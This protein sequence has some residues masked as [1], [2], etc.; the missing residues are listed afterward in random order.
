VMFASTRWRLT[1]WFVAVLALILTV[2]GVVV[3]FTTRASLFD[4]VDDSLRSRTTTE[5]RLLGPRLP[6]QIQPQQSL[7]NIVVGPVSTAGGYF[8]ALVDSDGELLAG[9]S[10]VDLE[11][12]AGQET[13]EKALAGDPSFE[14]T[15][16]STGEDLRVYVMPMEGYQATGL[17]LEVGRSIEPER[18]ALNRLIFI[19]GGGGAAGLVLALVGGFF[20]AG[21]ALRPIGA[22][23]DRQRAFVAD[24]SHELRTPL[25][26]IRAN[27]ELL[28]RHPQEPVQA[29][30]PSL[31]DIIREIDG[32]STLVS[33]M[34]TLAKADAGT[35]P[36][37][38]TEV[39][40]HDLVEDVGKQM[41]V[42][43]DKKGL[44]LDVRVDGPAQVRGD[45][46]RLRELLLI[47]LDNAIKFTDAAGTVGLTLEADGGKAVMRVKDSGSGIPPEALPHVF[48]RFYRAD[49][50]RSQTEGGAGL[51]LAV[52]KWLVESHQGSIRVDS[53]PGK[54]TTFTVELPIQ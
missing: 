18:E 35:T 38:F 5:V 37:V 32:L 17:V 53:H 4:A 51:G 29:N 2:L 43:A 26:L 20:L 34:L 19:L 16:S 40:L 54:G 23:M 24:A 52:A 25:S 30:M 44:Q 28:Q 45:E 8:Y 1:I 14:N 49:K 46:V 11:G 39:A 33:Q 15:S 21:R 6:Q 7:Q 47:L 9:T 48:D 10:N 41:R 3:F 12:L 42:L 31:N 50:A 36:F 22:A 27:A 13:I